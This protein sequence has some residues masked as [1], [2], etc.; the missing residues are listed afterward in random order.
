MDSTQNYLLNV[1]KNGKNEQKQFIEECSQDSQ[2]FEKPIKRQKIISFATETGKQK[3]IESNRKVL[4]ACLMHDL[5]GSI[6][7]ISLQEKVD[8]AQMLKYPLT[9]VPLSLSHVDGTMLS[10]PKS[11]LLTFLGTKG[12]MATPD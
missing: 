7:Y 4:S 5:F 10:T 3:I 1:F 9:R 2:Q 8:M 11:A 12:T 6:L